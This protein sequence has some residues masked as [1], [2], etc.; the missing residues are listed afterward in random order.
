MGQRA[1]EKLIHQA[2]TF[3]QKLCA[4]QLGKIITTNNVLRLLTVVWKH[5]CETVREHLLNFAIDQMRTLAA[6]PE[7]T[8]FE[9]EHILIAFEIYKRM[10]FSNN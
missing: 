4:A 1:R 5:N 7:W 8:E 9:R 3:L 6:L 10:T 2:R